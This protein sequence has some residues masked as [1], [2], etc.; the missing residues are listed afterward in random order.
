LYTK[1]TIEQVVNSQSERLL[2]LAPGLPRELTL[3]RD[4]SSH[5]LIISGIRRCGKSTLLQQIHTGFQGTSVY[6][7]FEDPRLAGFDLEDFNR[8]HEL[9][10]EKGINASFF[11]Q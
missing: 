6:L 11:L 5:A 4:L 3:P 9:V 8:L 1:Y 10:V 2:R 7:N